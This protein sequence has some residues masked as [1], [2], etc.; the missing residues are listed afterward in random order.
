MYYNLVMTQDN[1]SNYA[2]AVV[3]TQTASQAFESISQLQ[4]QLDQQFPAAQIVVRQLSQGPPV[5]APIEI[6]LYGTSLKRLRSIG[7]EIQQVLMATPGVIQTRT[8]FDVQRTKLVLDT[9]ESKAHLLGLSLND[10]ASQFQATLEG[11]TGEHCWNLRK[12]S[13][14]VCDWETMSVKT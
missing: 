1:K 5:I 9:D 11:T 13:L 3:T 10:V 2:Q 12:N 14:F 6:R 4:K 7:T 8:T